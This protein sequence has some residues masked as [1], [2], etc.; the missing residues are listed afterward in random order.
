MGQDVTDDG[1][2]SAYLGP[3]TIDDK[4]YDRYTAEIEQQFGV[5]LESL[6]LARIASRWGNQHFDHVMALR[7]RATAYAA[8]LEKQRQD[9]QDFLGERVPG[10]TKSYTELAD[11]VRAQ[12]PDGHDPI[13]PILPRLPLA[14][15]AF[16]VAEAFGFGDGTIR[17][18]SDAICF[19]VHQQ[20]YEEEA[21]RLLSRVQAVPPEEIV[22]KS[23]PP[24]DGSLRFA[25]TKVADWTKAHGRSGKRDWIATVKILECYGWDLERVDLRVKATRLK[26]RYGAADPAE[27]D[28]SS[29]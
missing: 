18:N 21:A 15:P 16:L 22:S 7:R 27:G 1:W 12:H 2:V 5:K 19:D 26:D 3:R 10:M 24:P 28:D 11:A 6:E 14:R 8:L 20:L 25:A 17:M 13:V 29:P 23:G 9:R 4:T